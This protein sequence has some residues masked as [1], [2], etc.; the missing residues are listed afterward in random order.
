MSKRANFL[1]SQFELIHITDRPQF[2]L[3]VLCDLSYHFLMISGGI[4]VNSTT[5][6]SKVTSTLT[7]NLNEYKLLNRGF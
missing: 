7:Y 5:I 4:K 1:K 3:L 6:R 2:S